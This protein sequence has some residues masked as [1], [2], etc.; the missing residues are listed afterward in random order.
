MV[1]VDIIAK[2][3]MLFHSYKEFAEFAGVSSATAGK[4]MKNKSLACLNRYVKEEDLNK[5]FVL[6]NTKTGVEY[7]CINAMTLGIYLEKDL[8]NNELSKISSLKMNKIFSTKINGELIVKIDSNLSEIKDYQSSCSKKYFNPNKNKNDYKNNREKNLERKDKWAKGNKEK[9]TEYNR[10]Y[11]SNR[12]KTDSDFRLRVNLRNRLRLALKTYKKSNS[13]IN[14]TGCS[15][16]FLKSHLFDKFKNGMNWE[17]Y[18]KEWCV[19]HVIPCCSFDL[20]KEDDQRKCFHYLNLQ[21]LWNI[22]NLKKGSS[23]TYYDSNT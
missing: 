8:T 1:I 12:Y 22:E 15:L 19:D 3:S 23:M 17:N 16:E 2:K 4:F 18:G 9:I 6:K 14:L 11:S 20:S 5:I 7:E 21:P 13:T 10:S